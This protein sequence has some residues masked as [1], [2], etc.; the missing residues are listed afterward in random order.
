MTRDE[1]PEEERYTTAMANEL[2]SWNSL[3]VSPV[4]NL[5]C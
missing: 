5:H 2:G 1:N 3:H 4:S